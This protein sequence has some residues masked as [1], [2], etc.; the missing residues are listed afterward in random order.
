MHVDL[1]RLNKYAFVLL[2][3]SHSYLLFRRNHRQ[4]SRTQTI[5]L[6]EKKWWWQTGNA[7]ICRGC[8]FFPFKDRLKHIH[9]E[10]GSEEKQHTHSRTQDVRY[11]WDA[12]LPLK[13]NVTWLIHVCPTFYVRQEICIPSTLILL[14]PVTTNVILRAAATNKSWNVFTDLYLLLSLESLKSIRS[15]F[16]NNL[17]QAHLWH[18]HMRHLRKT[19]GH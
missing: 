14:L 15:R 17:L 19:W 12:S 11:F 1:I 5:K 4:H 8:F 16:R 2:T 9:Q 6:N 13:R 3:H 18:W 10:L 7:Q